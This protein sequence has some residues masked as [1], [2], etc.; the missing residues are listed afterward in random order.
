MRLRCALR[1]SG[2]PAVVVVVVVDCSHIVSYITA[3]RASRTL[4]C[5]YT[6][7]YLHESC[8][9]VHQRA[10]IVAAGHGGL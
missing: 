7:T 3:C 10:V 8:S 6:I 4:L 1:V 9:C 2:A 5:A